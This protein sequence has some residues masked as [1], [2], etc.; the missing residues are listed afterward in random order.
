MYYR[1]IHIDSVSVCNIFIPIP[2]VQVRYK[3][4]T[5]IS[6]I[7]HPQSRTHHINEAH[8]SSNLYN[9]RP[10]ATSLTSAARDDASVL[11]V[12]V[13]FMLCSLAPL[14]THWIFVVFTHIDLCNPSYDTS[15][16]KHI[17][18]NS[19]YYTLSSAYGRMPIIFDPFRERALFRTHVL[20]CSWFRDCDH[21][22]GA[23][24]F[25]LTV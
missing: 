19:I 20:H 24:I 4:T 7:S 2:C 23:C 5:Y 3:H 18:I 1:R 6:S 25:I 10:A 21:R 14:Q 17:N 22:R 13:V 8:A 9:A 11:W 16:W 12:C 15:F